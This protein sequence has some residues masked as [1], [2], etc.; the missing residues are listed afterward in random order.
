MSEKCATS[1][2]GPLC[3]EPTFS[4]ILASGDNIPF[5][6]LLATTATQTIVSVMVTNQTL[7]GQTFQV[8]LKGFGL[9]QL[10]Q[11][12]GV[13]YSDPFYINVGTSIVQPTIGTKTNQP[14]SFDLFPAD[15]S[16]HT[17]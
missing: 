10:N 4:L 15:I 8:K 16:Y 13:G 12:Y 9:D 14:P 5:T 2:S 6:Y 11:P 1:S 17:N 7:M 3:G